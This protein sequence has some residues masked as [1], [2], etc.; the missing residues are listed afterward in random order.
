MARVPRQPLPTATLSRPLPGPSFGGD[1]IIRLRFLGALTCAAANHCGPDGDLDFG[2]SSKRKPKAM[3]P[4]LLMTVGLISNIAGAGLFA[5]DLILTKAEA[6]ELAAFY[7][8]GEAEHEKRRLLDVQD[9][10]AKSRNAQIGLA[11]FVLGFVG[12]L[13]GTWLW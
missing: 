3:L 2:L 6:T 4:K 7:R 8:P 5:W 10:L 11:L 12:Q 13:V 9:A 1:K